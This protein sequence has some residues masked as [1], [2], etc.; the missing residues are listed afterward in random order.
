MITC[1]LEN[2]NHASLRH[3]TVNTVVIRHGAVLLVKRSPGLLEAGKWGP[4]GGFVDRDETVP[5]A[6]IRKAYEESGRQIDNLRLLWIN[7]NPDRPGE[8]R[9]NVEFIFTAQAVAQTGQPDWESAEIRWFPLDALPPAHDVAFDHHTSLQIY[10]G[11]QTPQ[12]SFAEPS[13]G[14][15]STLSGGSFLYPQNG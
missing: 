1:Q 5:Q 11:H 15:S 7:D 12:E 4:V 2:A 3:V 14:Q 13:C 10:L 9:Q 8:D 6:A